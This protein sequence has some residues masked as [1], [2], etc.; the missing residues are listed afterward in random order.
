MDAVRRDRPRSLRQLAGPLVGVAAAAALLAGCGGSGR[1]PQAQATS[2]AAAGA[3]QARGA[4]LAG[5]LAH[6]L[7]GAR[8]ITAVDLDAARAELGLPR[9]AG[10]LVDGGRAAGSRSERAALKLTQLASLALPFVEDRPL[11]AALDLRRV[12]AAVQF[13][14]VEHGGL[15]IGTSQPPG[16][17]AA[18]LRRG[19]WR[20]QGGGFEYRRGAGGLLGGSKVALFPGGLVLA[21][22]PDDADSSA[23]QRTAPSD[24]AR[25]LALLERSRAPA[26]FAAVQTTCLRGILADERL[27]PQEGTVSLRP[28]RPPKRGDV[29][30]GPGDPALFGLGLVVSA[31]VIRQGRVTVRVR[32]RPGSRAAAGTVVDLAR[33]QPVYRCA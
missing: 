31:P 9:D 24:D 30:L 1:R 13:G 4:T 32:Y 16:A 33:T 22:D 25:L 23:E 12:H 28:R 17:I 18:A 15:L 8:L 7:P 5:L 21:A 19:G 20:A 3:G 11:L 27:V 14:G 10:L 29:V 6:V 2:A 26:R